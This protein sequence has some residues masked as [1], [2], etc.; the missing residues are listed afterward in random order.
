MIKKALT[1]GLIGFAAW[2][3]YR[4]Y[5]M[6]ESYL[7][8]VDGENSEALE[9]SNNFKAVAF[10][11]GEDILSMV[12]DKPNLNMGLS[13]QGIGFIKSW[14]KAVLKPYYATKKE[15]EL[16]ILTVGYGVT[17]SDNDLDLV[18]KYRNG[19][20]KAEAETMFLKRVAVDE[21]AIAKGI[22][23]KLT[24]SQFDALVS[25]RYNLGSLGVAAS[26]LYN[27]LQI[28]DFEKAADSFLLYVNQKGEFKM[29]LYKRR[30]AEM[31]MFR[32]GRYETI[33]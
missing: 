23:Y 15:Q 31:N 33:F 32:F 30:A 27:A 19:I 29:G 10:G 4:R 6:N 28:G 1:V 7:L 24:Q 11:I 3:I 16:G 13:L 21:V 22:R 20:T 26:T 14:E 5:T 9:S 18:E 8:T 12:K 17:Y 25:L 2:W